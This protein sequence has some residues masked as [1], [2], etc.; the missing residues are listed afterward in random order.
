MYFNRNCLIRLHSVT[1]FEASLTDQKYKWN[2]VNYYLYFCKQH[3]L[4]LASN[5][6][7]FACKY[8][9]IFPLIHRVLFQIS[10]FSTIKWHPYIDIKTTNTNHEWKVYLFAPLFVYQSTWCANK[11]SVDSFSIPTNICSEIIQITITIYVPWISFILPD[12]NNL[13]RK[14]ILTL[15][16]KYSVCHRA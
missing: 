1:Y 3:D 12:I 8:V 2:I 5:S 16:H 15:K 13:L 7:S 14:S 6:Y 4:Y 9:L 10:L 11:I